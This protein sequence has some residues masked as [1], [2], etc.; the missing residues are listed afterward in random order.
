[1]VGDREAVGG[2]GGVI[3]HSALVVAPSPLVRG[4]LRGSAMKIG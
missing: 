4:L 3:R 2:E 1:V